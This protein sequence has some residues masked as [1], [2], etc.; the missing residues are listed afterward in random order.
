MP[1]TFNVLLKDLDKSRFFKGEKGLY[2]NLVLYE[3]ERGSESA[4]Y[5]DYIVKQQGEEG[6]RMPILG[7]GKYW[8]P[9][10]RG[11]GDRG[12]RGG[13][14]YGRGGGQ[15]RGFR[16]RGRRRGDTEDEGRGEEHDDQQRRM[17]ED[18]YDQ[19]RREDP[20]EIPF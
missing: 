13:G 8:P 20:D 5:G 11:G 3:T 1:I 17:R 15:S 4:D 7:N 19:R 10:R 2:A 12:R 6:D 16:N 14:G 9:R 18:D